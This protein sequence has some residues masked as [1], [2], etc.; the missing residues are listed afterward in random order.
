[1]GQCRNAHTDTHTH[2]FVDTGTQT[3]SGV[4]SMG[5]GALHCTALLTLQEFHWCHENHVDARFS[6]SCQL[7]SFISACCLIFCL[8]RKKRIVL[9]VWV[10]MWATGEGLGSC[11]VERLTLSP[12]PSR[13]NWQHGVLKPCTIEAQTRSGSK[14]YHHR[15]LQKSQKSPWNAMKKSPKIQTTV[16]YWWKILHLT[17]TEL[18]LNCINQKRLHFLD[19]SWE[20]S[21]DKY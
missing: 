7:V 14:W 20:F 8:G 10:W 3:G 4:W 1:M 13:V 9:F 6:D 19:R 21:L 11:H 16:W 12:S 18:N 15:Q 5:G 2:T 17:D